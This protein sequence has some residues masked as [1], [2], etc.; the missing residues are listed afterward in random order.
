MATWSMVVKQQPIWRELE[1][2]NGMGA[3]CELR[4]WDLRESNSRKA[5]RDYGRPFCNNIAQESEDSE[6]TIDT[7]R[8]A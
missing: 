4:T 3:R 7:A 2:E 1:A 8:A 5:W 6:L